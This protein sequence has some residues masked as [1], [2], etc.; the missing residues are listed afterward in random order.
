MIARLRRRHRRTW[1]ALAVLLPAIVAAAWR[2]R[3][4]SPVMERLPAALTQ[5][6]KP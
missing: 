4:P 6:A 1:I 3:R 5:E 2:V